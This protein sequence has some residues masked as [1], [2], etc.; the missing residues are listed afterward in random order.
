M[1]KRK[2]NECPYCENIGD[3]TVGNTVLFCCGGSKG[4]YYKCEKCGAEW[5]EVTKE[6]FVK[7]KRIN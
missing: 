1:E 7:R 2:E 5:K 3:G 4:E 6:V